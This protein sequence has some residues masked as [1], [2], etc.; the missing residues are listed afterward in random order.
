MPVFP[1]RTVSEALN[2]RASAG[3]G[4]DRFA[5]DLGCSQTVPAAYAARC[6]NSRRLMGASEQPKLRVCSLSWTQT[7]ALGYPLRKQN[8]AEKWETVPSGRSF[9]GIYRR[10]SPNDIL[11]VVQK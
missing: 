8:A 9:A 1:S 6:R 10:N 5:S 11:A 7:Y 4:N 3:I 2:F